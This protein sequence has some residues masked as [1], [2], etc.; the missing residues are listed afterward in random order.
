MV[1]YQQRHAVLEL[2]AEPVV[3]ILYL[4]CVFIG[5]CLKCCQL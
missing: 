2:R 1:E 3:V 4:A 5:N